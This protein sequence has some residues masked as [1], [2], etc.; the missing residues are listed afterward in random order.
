MSLIKT[1]KKEYI[2][3]GVKVPKE[4]YYRLK[5]IAWRKRK[6]VSDLIREKIDMIILEDENDVQ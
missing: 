3:M 5:D 1:R 6:T 2:Q 4:Q